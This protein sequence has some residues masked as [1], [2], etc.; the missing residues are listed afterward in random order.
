MPWF[1][2]KNLD[3]KTWMR[4][5]R[6]WGRQSFQNWVNIVKLSVKWAKGW[7]LG[8]SFEQTGNEIK[9][10]VENSIKEKKKKKKRGP[11]W[12]S[13]LNWSS[14][15]VSHPQFSGFALPAPM[16]A[17]TCIS[18]PVFWICLIHPS[19]SFI[20]SFL[21]LPCLLPSLLLEFFIRSA[22]LCQN[23]ILQANLVNW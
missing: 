3:E 18:P 13:H 23:K 8:T 9:S 21:N 7:V 5:R 20:P 22:A 15:E 10:H 1:M 19:R 4:I 2:S 12:V 14:Y 11:N 17:H 6:N 16:C